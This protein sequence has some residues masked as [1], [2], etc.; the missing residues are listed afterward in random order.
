MKLHVWAAHLPD[1]GSDLTLAVRQQP[2]R[3]VATYNAILQLHIGSQSLAC[4]ERQER[5]PNGLV[6]LA[7]HE[8]QVAGACRAKAANVNLM[9]RGRRWLPVSQ[10][11]CQPAQQNSI[12]VQKCSSKRV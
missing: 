6:G 11:L 9:E 2:L 8:G 3:N 10:L 12:A 7:M 1:E 5:L 4:E